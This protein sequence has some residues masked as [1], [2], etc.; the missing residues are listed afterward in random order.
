MVGFAGAVP[1]TAQT[2]NFPRFNNGHW[3][4]PEQMGLG[5]NVGFI[6]VIYDRYMN[7]A[8]LG[9]KHY[10]GQGVSNSGQESNWRRY[11]SSSSVLKEHWGE[12]P[13]SEFDFICLEEYKSKG[14]LSYSETWSLCFVEAP[15]TD[16]WYNKLVEK[17]SWKVKE[18]IS[19]R[20]K[21]RL[22]NIVERLRCSTLSKAA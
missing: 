6:Y 15:T 9:K 14:T 3:N 17:V 8:Y 2:L 13:K 16:V 1:K 5:K 22:N 12:R 20:H 10:R 4:F 11:M 7:K 21:V 18:P 19:E